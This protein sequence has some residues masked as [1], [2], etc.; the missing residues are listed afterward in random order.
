MINEQQLFHALI[1]GRPVSSANNHRAAVNKSTGRAFMHSDP[2]YKRWYTGAIK[3]IGESL[4]RG[5]HTIVRVPVQSKS[6]RNRAGMTSTVTNPLFHDE[7]RTIAI[8]WFFRPTVVYKRDKKTNEVLYKKQSDAAIRKGKA[9]EPQTVAY[10]PDVDNLGKGVYDALEAAG[11]LSND[12]LNRITTQIDMPVLDPDAEP[13]VAVEVRYFTDTAEDWDIPSVCPV[14]PSDPSTYMPRVFDD[15]SKWAEQRAREQGRI[16]WLARGGVDLPPPVSKERS[17]KCKVLVGEGH[18]EQELWWSVDEERWGRTV[19]L[20]CGGCGEEQLRYETPLEDKVHAQVRAA[21][22]HLGEDIGDT[23]PPVDHLRYE[24]YMKAATRAREKLHEQYRSQYCLVRAEDMPATGWLRIE[25][26]RNEKQQ[27][28]YP[29]DSSSRANH[30]RNAAVVLS[31]PR[32]QA[33]SSQERRQDNRIVSISSPDP[34]ESHIRGS[35]SSVDGGDQQDGPGDER[36]ASLQ[37]LVAIR[38]RAART[39]RPSSRSAA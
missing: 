29:N 8:L 20:I 1:R 19:V 33:A 27:E 17:K 4:T 15:A 25:E 11:V 10:W 12:K 3:Q 31:S 14:I 30:N 5:G 39:T 32:Q 18:V 34:Y 6:G 24:A 35:I 28:L 37:R 16:E 36:A 13:Y 38:N 23:P 21:F 2:M 26:L 22:H 7:Q 9:P